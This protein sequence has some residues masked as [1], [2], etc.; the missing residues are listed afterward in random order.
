MKKAIKIICISLLALLSLIIIFF[1]SLF[2]INKI[3]LK[4]EA[5]K[6]TPYG[7]GFE[8][9]GEKMHYEINGDGDKTIVLLPGYM[10]A[11]PI[12]DFKPLSDEL[13]KD[14][15]VIT[16]EPLG[17]GLSD[18]T[19]KKR[20]LKHL[21]HEVHN[22]LQSLG[23]TKYVLMGHSI[24]G[25]YTLD[26]IQQYPNEVEAFVGIDSSLPA[27]G[28]AEDNQEDAIQFLSQSGLYRLLAK[29]NPD[30]LNAPDI[31]TDLKEQYTYLS[32][33][34]IGSQA[35]YN[36]GKEMPNNFKQ[37]ANVSYPKDLPVLY[38]LATESTNDDPN[39]EAIHQDMIK[40]SLHADVKILDGG[41]YLH[42]TKAK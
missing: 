29:T 36:E 7:E 34:N 28:G 20:D 2:V 38:L 33:K 5:K 21:T 30:L 11:S 15:R 10:T 9:D 4:N 42:H 23:V 16:I 37:V 18:D 25:V 35:T 24:S 17:Y 1:A 12:I 3:Q 19:N 41:H 14:Y 31:S 22:L 8:I 27:Q 13:K 39:W 26:Y 40:N 32:L 6:I